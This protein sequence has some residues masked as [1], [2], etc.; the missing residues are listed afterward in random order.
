MFV[1]WEC[2]FGI[3]YFFA[4]IC[5]CEYVIWECVFRLWGCI[6][7]VVVFLVCC[8]IFGIWECVFGFGN[9]Y[10]VQRAFDASK[11]AELKEL[12]ELGEQ[13][14]S[15]VHTVFYNQMQKK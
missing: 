14:E 1:T 12:K 5:E 8:H 3:L 9:L 7:S 2:I 15:S 10:L 13:L 4:C 6:F 11:I